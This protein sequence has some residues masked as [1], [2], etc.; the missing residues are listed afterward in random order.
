MRTPS[1]PV[2]AVG[3]CALAWPALAADWPQ[4][5]GPDRSNVSTETGLLKAW[6]QNG[7]PLVWTYA[8]AGMGYSAPVI[9][10]DR[11]YG[12]GAR[13]NQEVVYAL[14]VGTGKLLWS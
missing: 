4:W 8:D 5:G 14:D 13:E 11:L 10:G 12:A 2:L 7:P 3:L 6:P 1:L 9:V